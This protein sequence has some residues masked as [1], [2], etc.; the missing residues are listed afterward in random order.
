MALA[1]MSKQYIHAFAVNEP[2]I[3]NVNALAKT[4]N[5]IIKNYQ[6]N[7]QLEFNK[8]IESSFIGNSAQ[9]I[10][11]FLEDAEGNSGFVSNF[12]AMYDS[13]FSYT[14]A[15]GSTDAGI[16]GADYTL[17]TFAADRNGGVTNDEL[18]AQ[19][20]KDFPN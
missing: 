13:L 19:L 20:N 5:N 11:K 3:M 6:K 18:F 16:Q 7:M 10:I 17:R 4:K 12:K 1:A 2:L 8:R 14:F 15:S 9:E